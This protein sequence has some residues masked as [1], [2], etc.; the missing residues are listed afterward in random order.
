MLLGIPNDLS[1]YTTYGTIQARLRHGGPAQI[2]TAPTPTAPKQYLL[3]PRSV[4][5]V[6]EEETVSKPNAEAEDE[7][8]DKVKDQCSEIQK[9][10]IDREKLEAIFPN[11]M[12]VN[13][14]ILVEKLSSKNK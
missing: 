12:V 6:Q 14:F 7:D 13:I 3:T 8:K 10:D 1:T 11:F 5:S 4:K 2:Q 9:F